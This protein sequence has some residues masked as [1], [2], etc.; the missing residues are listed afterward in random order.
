[1]VSFIQKAQR[2]SIVRIVAAGIL[3]AFSITQII[4]P[5]PS[6]VQAQMVMDLPKPGTMVHLSPAFNPPVLKGIKV[7]PDNPFRFDFILDQGSSPLF[8]IKRGPGGVF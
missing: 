5:F 6:V 1:M 7:H 8:F 4:F 3:F 2:Y